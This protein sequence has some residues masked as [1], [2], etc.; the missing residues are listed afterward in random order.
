MKYYL[1]MEPQL[2]QVGMSQ[3]CPPATHLPPCYLPL[4]LR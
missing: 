4:S 3:C 1:T 2:F